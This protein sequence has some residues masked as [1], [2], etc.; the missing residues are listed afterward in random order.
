MWLWW[1]A[2]EFLEHMSL[3]PERVWTCSMHVWS[4]EE[5]SRCTSQSPPSVR[6]ALK[7][8]A[9]QN[10]LSALYCLWQTPRNCWSDFLERSPMNTIP[11]L[12]SQSNPNEQ[13]LSHPQWQIQCLHVHPAVAKSCEFDIEL[14][15]VTLKR[16]KTSERTKR[17]KTTQE[18]VTVLV[19]VFWACWGLLIP[20]LP[21]LKF[22]NNYSYSGCISTSQWL[23]GWL[24]AWVSELRS[25]QTCSE[26]VTWT[27]IRRYTRVFCQTRQCGPSRCPLVH[28]APSIAALSNL[29]P[30]S[31]NT[32][33]SERVNKIAFR[34]L[35]QQLCSK[36]QNSSEFK[37]KL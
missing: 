16:L 32:T 22:R 26:R 23:S 2:E 35:A 28:S 1:F 15:K 37:L 11:C 10:I 14:A 18:V 17:I 21:K 3:Q 7:A 36:P 34:H 29:E 24:T 33:G 12:H 8:P 4:V 9:S 6:K 25:S 31:T 13:S 30:N 5:G 27:K 19:P 20:V